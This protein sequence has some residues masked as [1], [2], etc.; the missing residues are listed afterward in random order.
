MREIF[1][2]GAAD[3]PPNAWPVERIGAKA[4]SLARL[5]D[6]GLRVPPAFV[7]GTGMCCEVL[8]AGGRL[9]DAARAD[10]RDAVSWLERATHRRF[11]GQPPLLVSVRSS[12]PISMPGMLE[13]VLNVGLTAAST[14]GL[15][16]LTGNPALVWDTS[17]RFAEGFAETVLGCESAPFAKLADCAMAAAGAASIDEVDPLT[18]RDLASETAR[19][20]ETASGTSMFTDPYAQLQAAVEAV[21][22]SWSKTRARDYRRLGQLDGASGTAVIVQ[23][24]VFGNGLATSGSGVGFTRNPSTG[25]DDLYVD[26]LFNAQGE[27]VVSGRRRVAETTTLAAA[28]PAIDAELGR[29]KT[30][31]ETE[32]RDMQDFE[33]TVEDG[34]LHFLQC[35]PGKRTPWAALHIATDL[36][37]SGLIAPDVALARLAPYDVES[38]HRVRLRPDLEVE[39]V[40][41]AVPASLGVAVGAIAF[42]A[43]RARTMA[44]TAPVVLVRPELT[45]DDVGGLAASSGILTAVGG[46][47]SHAAV[48]ARQLGKVCLAGCSALRIDAV[49]RRCVLGTRGF[50]EGDVI[51][52]D[53]ETGGV[54][55]GAVPT[56]VER[57]EGALAEVRRWRG[58]A[59]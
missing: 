10:L 39:V 13:T 21:F 31:L 57:P 16:K 23:A 24:M 58:L 49:N 50:A 42:D 38:I 20:V 3:R 40:A 28:L 55:S 43:H 34:V 8:K 33:F 22:G 53:G 48:I 26:F 52:L 59:A 9:P 51:T 1:F 7:L 32:F 41:S 18:L 15:L 46:R 5:A 44:A 30:V 56:V 2:V 36:V 27:D 14:R 29:T 45:T 17:R 54:Y 12:P 11:G 6:L 25:E 19:L 35:R 4:A 37:R 47:T